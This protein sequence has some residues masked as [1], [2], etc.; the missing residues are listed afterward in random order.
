MLCG[1]AQRLDVFHHFQFALQVAGSQRI[2]LSN[3]GGRAIKHNIATGFTRAWTNVHE[4]VSLVHQLRV[5]L[6]HHQGVTGLFQTL[7]GL[8]H[9]RNV[10]GVQAHR[11][12]V[13]YKQS[14]HQRTAQCR[15][16]IDSLY[17]TTT[18][19]SA[20]PV[21]CQVTQAHLNEEAQAG[22]NFL[23]HQITGL[24]ERAGQLQVFKQLSHF[25]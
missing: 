1:I 2:C 9:A 18:Q 25:Q 23:Q 16:Q 12:F 6:N 17:F 22:A 11:G 4:P 15:G 14:I 7:H 5:V 8:S 10:A 24:I 20:L 13:Q 3:F 21:Q 19:G